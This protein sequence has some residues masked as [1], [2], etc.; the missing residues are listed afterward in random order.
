MSVVSPAS[1]DRRL[2]SDHA[3]LLTAAGL[4]LL[5][6]CSALLTRS[7]RF[8]PEKRLLGWLF[9]QNSELGTCQITFLHPVLHTS[10]LAVLLQVKQRKH[11]CS[12]SELGSNSPNS[13]DNSDGWRCMP[14]PARMRST[15]A[16][17]W[18]STAFEFEV[19]IFFSWHKLMAYAKVKESF[20]F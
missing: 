17:V 8:R 11:A 2:R 9:S 12:S 14:A 7:S 4:I 10:M 5:D 3:G 18:C 20:S 1:H 6:L 16:M 13:V 15:T 19:S